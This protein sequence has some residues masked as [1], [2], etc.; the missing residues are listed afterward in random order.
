MFD[1]EFRV[2][3]EIVERGRQIRISIDD[4]EMP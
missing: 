1:F 2:Y 3:V 4:P